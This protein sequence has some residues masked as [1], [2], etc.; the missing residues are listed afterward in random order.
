MNQFKVSI[1]KNRYGDILSQAELRS[2]DV[3]IAK[4]SC[5][6]TDNNFKE[7]VKLVGKKGYP[8]CPATFKEGIK[9]KKTFV[10]SQV[11][12][13]YFDITDS[14]K[15]EASYDKIYD[16][17]KRY[18][19]PIL[20]AYDSYSQTF[21]DSDGRCT[22]FCFVFL[23]DAPLVDL[24]EA[25]AVQKAMMMI[26]PE[27]DKSCS[28]LKTYQGGN[29]VLYADHTMPTL[30]VEW[31]F[32][33]MCLCLL[34]RQGKTNYKRKII[35]FSR[36]TGVKLNDKKLPDLSIA[37]TEND[38]GKIDDNIMPKCIID[39]NSGKILSYLKYEINFDDRDESVGEVS[40]DQKESPERSHY[41]SKD[42]ES[43]SSSCKLYLDFVS[44]E[45]I[46]PWREL[47]GLA[48][49][50][51][52]AESGAKKFK[53]VIKAQS[54]YYQDSKYNDWE[55]Q[56]F[57]LKGRD[58]KPCDTFCPYHDTCPHGR[59]I[60][61]TLKPV[62]HQIERIA[63][64]GEIFVGLD[65]A[66]ADFSQQ[67]A[68][69][70]GSDDKIWHVIRCQTALGK[71]ATIL[72]FLQS[73]PGNVLIAVPTNKLKREVQERA[74]KLGLDIVASPSLHELEDDL[75][76]DVWDDI[77]DLY[78]MG[79]SPMD[80][81]NKAMEDG[82]KKCVRIIEGYKKEMMLF[83][84][85]DTAITTHRRLTGMDV[86]KYDLV[87]VDE[88]IIYSTIIPSRDSAAISDLKHLRKKLIPNDPLAVK[89][90][91]ILKQVKRLNFFTLKAIDYDET[92]A[93]IDM[94]INI[95]ALCS[96]K[97]FCYRMASEVESD[98]DEDCV[99]FVRP[100]KFPKNTK[101]IMLS[102][103]ADR[104]ICKYCFG[105]NGIK[106]Y[107][108]KEAAIT[109]T[110]YQYGDKPMGR[111][112]IR[113]DPAVI[114]RI[115]RWTG[116]K[117]TISFKEFHKYYEGDFHFGNCAGCD[118]LKGKDID[119]I[120]TPHQPD[121]IYKLFAYSLGYDIDD[122]LKPNTL[123]THNGFRFRFM[124][125]KDEVLQK[126]QFYMVESELEQAVGRARLLRCDCVVNL[127]SDF[128]LKQALLRESEYEDTT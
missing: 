83:S 99:T 82:D 64:Y 74:R 19:L 116:F 11:L 39:K 24:K 40:S 59:D 103:T 38:L 76:E 120:G 93:D 81:L 94:D 47:F 5:M 49:N 79:K 67:F 123:V 72:S 121:W 73:Y 30:D 107:D 37:D 25:E 127:F 70:V 112:S 46:L 104:D 8:F 98:L 32:M 114:E 88:D 126:I 69:A 115:K 6:I 124:T 110:L 102:A 97:H 68:E 95:P 2:M 23:L 14:E 113:K 22:K 56:F 57:Y 60:L 51:A 1:T 84:M 48:T 18:E 90:K 50:L 10:Q 45:R 77:E 42:I 105:E 89:I 86:S 36:E 109:G 101:Y 3:P 27:A 9:S 20:L 96:A 41:R 16:R 7:F 15:G 118:T 29:E 4:T 62:S 106:F 13:L 54:Y 28:V 75:P 12:A 58:K 35:K 44:G 108:C 66:H 43:L 87:I 53:S 33:K 100:I 92:Y 122:R 128:P 65:K 111:S 85:S 71:T 61:S 21:A 125:Y 63:N 78:N 26:F 52:Q 17:A 119:V 80:R 91:E 34:D 55:Y 117:N 31:L